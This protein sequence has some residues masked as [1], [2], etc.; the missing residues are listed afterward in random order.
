M[1]QDLQLASLAIPAIMLSPATRA[2]V[3]AELAA[4]GTPAPVTSPDGYEAAGQAIKKAK[5]LARRIED[6][7]AE[8]KA[9]LI[10]AGK[11]LDAIAKELA[12]PVESVASEYQRHFL[13]Y[14]RQVEAE[15]QRAIEA[16]RRA[17]AEAADAQAKAQREQSAR[18]EAARLANQPPPAPLPPVVAPPVRPVVMPPPELPKSR[19][20]LQTPEFTIPDADAV[21]PAFLSPDPVKINEYARDHRATIIALCKKSANGVALIHGVAFTIRETVRG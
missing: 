8:A 20:V 10:A 1:T 18:E 16:Q 4:I 15:R 12:A 2:A 13:A 7:R 9:P 3:T 19:A 5:A 6:A 14:Q 21:H 11:A 17:D